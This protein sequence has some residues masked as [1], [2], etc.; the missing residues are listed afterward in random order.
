[1]LSR[2]PR[3]VST[4]N[5]SPCLAAMRNYSSSRVATAC[6]FGSPRKLPRNTLTRFGSHSDRRRTN[7]GRTQ[8]HSFISSA[9]SD[10]RF[11]LQVIGLLDKF[12]PCAET[13]RSPTGPNLQRLLTYSFGKLW[14]DHGEGRRQSVRP[15]N[16]N[17]TN[18]N[19]SART[20]QSEL[21]NRSHSY[22]DR[23]EFRGVGQCKLCVDDY[24][25]AAE[26][27]K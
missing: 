1:M 5:P 8:T 11:R 2:R 19:R 26:R 23:C 24:R 4:S 21:E 3:A 6:T 14:C 25:L 10:G 18:E 9:R 16:A 7:S 22:T 20:G 27:F 15:V 13:V 17:K 12:S